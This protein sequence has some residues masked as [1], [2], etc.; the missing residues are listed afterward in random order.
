MSAHIDCVYILLTCCGKIARAFH[1]QSRQGD[2]S[3]LSK[4]LL[5]STPYRGAEPAGVETSSE[6]IYNGASE[7]SS[8][9]TDHVTTRLQEDGPGHG[10]AEAQRNFF[11]DLMRTVPHPIAIITARK[12]DVEDDVEGTV[13]ATVSSFNSVSIRPD[14]IV[15]FNLRSD[16]VTFQTIQE[17]KYCTVTFPQMTSAGTDLARRFTRGNNPSP[18]T[19]SHPDRSTPRPVQ[20]LFDEHKKTTK[21]KYFPPSVALAEIE[22]SQKSGLAFAM[23]CEYQGSFPVG[24]HV[25]VT[26]RM[27]AVPSKVTSLGWGGMLGRGE[28]VTSDVTL[29][30]VHGTFSH[31]DIGVPFANLWKRE[32]PFGDPQDAGTDPSTK[33]RWYKDRLKIIRLAMLLSRGSEPETEF[34]SEAKTIVASARKATRLK[35]DL[36]EEY[37][38][39]YMMRAHYWQAK[40]EA[41]KER[42][43]TA[44]SSQPSKSP[45]RTGDAKS[46]SGLPGYQKLFV[47]NKALLNDADLEEEIATY[48]K[49]LSALNEEGEENSSE[50]DAALADA[51]SDPSLDVEEDKASRKNQ[52]R[53]YFNEQIFLLEL[54][55]TRRSE[56][57]PL[58]NIKAK[59]GTK[60]N[61]ERAM[62]RFLG[63]NRNESL[64]TLKGKYRRYQ[65]QIAEARLALM[66]LEEASEDNEVVSTLKERLQFFEPRA[67][68]V[69]DIIKEKAKQMD[70]QSL[71]AEN[72]KVPTMR[73][74]EPRK[75]PSKATWNVPNPDGHK[76]F[77]RV[78]GIGIRAKEGDSADQLDVDAE[79]PTIEESEELQREAMRWKA[80]R[81]QEY[82]VRQQQEGEEASSR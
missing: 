20:W 13:A 55:Q 50:I 67:S 80:Q 10:T 22:D 64:A 35:I 69:L 81:V 32:D 77:R 19:I 27:T 18:F 41:L 44:S 24:D 31:S 3:R 5:S 58:R 76:P 25:I 78:S 53:S 40:V 73:P 47:R 63:A 74:N 26:A 79:S 2:F 37:E 38:R 48:K 11:V 65:Y 8:L 33:L 82:L 17:S 52:L 51:M 9:P 42:K 71:L 23:L 39:L 57:L 14:V 75:V 28:W 49:R 66:G 21:L 36:L 29:A 46:Y 45:A 4:R 70:R 30:H 72:F 6:Q 16:S 1:L 34:A 59:A 54:A 68:V 60:G 62:R 43:A 56:S 61:E 12:Q 15:S 7:S